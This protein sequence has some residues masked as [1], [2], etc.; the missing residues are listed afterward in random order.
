MASD[1]IRLKQC[2]LSFAAHATS[3]G[4]SETAA[5]TDL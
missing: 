3:A 4:D 1:P 2:K 5:S